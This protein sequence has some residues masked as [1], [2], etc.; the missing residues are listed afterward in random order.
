MGYAHFAATTPQ[1]ERITQ[2]RNQ[3]LGFRTLPA[4]FQNINWETLTKA[5]ASHLIG[6]LKEL[7][8]QHQN[9]EVR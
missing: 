1:R 6:E 4:E 3:L 9:A 5:R 7:I 2:L 8:A